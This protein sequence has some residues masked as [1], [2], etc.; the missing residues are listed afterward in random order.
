MHSTALQKL[1]EYTHIFENE[2]L[3][4]SVFQQR[5]VDAVG[6]QMFLVG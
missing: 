4:T 2:L 5:H 6:C 3:P 1:L